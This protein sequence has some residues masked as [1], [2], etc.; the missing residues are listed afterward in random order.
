MRFKPLLTFKYFLACSLA[1]GFLWL[2]SARAEETLPDP[3]PVESMSFV[4][5]AS[6]SIQDT[7]DQAVELLGIPYRRGGSSP[8]TGF[9][10]SGF[11]IHVFRQGIGLILPHSARE[12]S[13]TGEVIL[14]EELKPGDLVFFNTM[15][16]TFSHVGIYL[17]NDQFVHSPRSGGQVRVEDLRDSYWNK[18]YNGARRVSE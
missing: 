8:Q 12:L 9:D 7:L 1:C 17:G 4:E 18:R 6:H 14:R 3:A 5:R 2:P 16:R 13:K 10:C 15:R 11:V